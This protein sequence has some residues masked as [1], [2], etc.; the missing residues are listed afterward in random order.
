[1]EV[2]LAGAK[3]VADEVEFD[4]SAAAGSRF[5]GS[6]HHGLGSG[7]EHGHDASSLVNAVG[8]QLHVAAPKVTS[9]S[10][11]SCCCFTSAWALKTMRMAFAEATV[12]LA[13]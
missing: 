11:L 3:Q 13:S 6:K 4:I 12:F 7:K 2:Q 5:A 10:T 8:Q 9:P 1:M